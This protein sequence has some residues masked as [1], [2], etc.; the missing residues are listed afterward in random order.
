MGKRSLIQKSECQKPIKTKKNIK[1]F[2]YHHYIES[3]FLVH[4]YYDKNQTFDVLILGTYG[5]KKDH[6]VENQKY[7]LPMAYYLWLGQGQLG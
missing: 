3:I 2:V 4:H 1:K 7:Q 5:I 6:N